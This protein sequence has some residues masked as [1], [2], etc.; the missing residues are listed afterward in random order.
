MQLSRP[1]CANKLPPLCSNPFNGPNIP[2]AHLNV[3]LLANC[4]TDGSYVASLVIK[5]SN[6]REAG[7]GLFTSCALYPG[8]SIGFYTKMATFVGNAH[9]RQAVRG[10][11][12]D[13]YLIQ[14][15]RR[16]ALP[17]EKN[18]FRLMNDGSPS[19]LRNNVEFIEVQCGPTPHDTHVAV[20][21]TKYIPVGAELLV[22]YG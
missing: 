10:Q 13:A 20:Y 17:D 16:T 3:F 15:G 21:T 4:E 14:I 1:G 11:A 6:I 8:M 7:R 9:L 5:K 22:N 2:Q 19:D 18:V 12:T